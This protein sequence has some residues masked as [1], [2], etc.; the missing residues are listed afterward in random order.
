MRTADPVAHPDRLILSERQDDGAHTSDVLARRARRGDLLRI[1]HG[2]Y[3]PT[4]AWLRSPPWDRHLIAT[5]ATG[6][7]DPSAVFCRETAL[8][9]HGLPLL[10][11][12]QT[13]Q[14]RTP[15]NWNTGQ[16]PRRRST[17]TAEPHHLA[18][19]WA[20]AFGE[21]PEGGAWMTRLQSPPVK[22]VQFPLPMRETPRSGLTPSAKRRYGTAI[23]RVA[24]GR[25]EFFTPDQ[26]AVAVEPVEL[27][28]VD[29]VA[30]MDLAA[31]VVVLDAFLAGRHC[32]ATVPRGNPFAHWL[33]C[34]PSLRAQRRWEAALAFAD[35]LAESPGE[36][37]SRVVISR[38]G[39]EVPALQHEIV[40]PHGGLRRTDFWWKTAG[41][42]GEFDGRQKYTRARELNGRT[43]GDVVMEERRRERDI[44]QQGYRML[45]WGWA[46]L[47]DLDR[48]HTLL[49]QAGVPR[50]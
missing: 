32:G 26:N 24:L 36:S 4:P 30:Q 31:G 50:R 21:P 11:T 28:I 48:M 46:E 44:E 35:P 15:Q 14:I 8:A 3:F 2:C 27:A 49:L 37:L 18:Q 29:T 13:V 38:L 33:D 6:L 25:G 16:R 17:G 41:I 42:V 7:T 9:L 45:R 39:F 23:Q 40:L 1:R 43:T 19:K 34:I 47:N 5:A 22:R 20:E 10:R 12:P